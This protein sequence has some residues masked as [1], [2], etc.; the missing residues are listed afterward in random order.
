MY[1]IGPFIGRLADIVGP[2]IVMIP[3]CILIVFSIFML[4]LST[5]YYQT[6][7]SEGVAFGLGSGCLFLIP[8]MAVSQ[9][10]SKRRGL[11]LGITASGSSL[12]QVI[13]CFVSIDTLIETQVVSAFRCSFPF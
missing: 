12:G 7:L 4:S 9:W 13:T 10:F 2:R 3:A 11:A 8:M 6:L 5:E 1:V